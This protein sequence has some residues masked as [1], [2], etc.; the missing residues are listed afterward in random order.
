MSLLPSPRDN[1]EYFEL[2]KSYMGVMYSQRFARLLNTTQNG[3]AHLSLGMR[4]LILI[5]S[6]FTS[7]CFC[8]LQLTLFCFFRPIFKSLYQPRCYCVPNDERMELLPRGLLL[9]VLPTLRHDNA[10]YLSLGLDAY[11]LVR[12]LNVLLLF[13]WFVGSLNV[14]VLAPLNW[15]GYGGQAGLDRL[16]LSNIAPARVYRLNAHCFMALV[17]L[18]LFHWLVIYELQS[19]VKIRQSYLLLKLYKASVMANTVLIKNVPSQWRNL[20]AI[21]RLF[22]GLA[23]GAVQN[24]WFTYDFYGVNDAVSDLRR[25]LDMLELDSVKQLKRQLRLRP[26]VDATFHPPIHL[27]AFVIPVLG[28]R[29]RLSLPGWIR[30]STLAPK[31]HKRQW[32]IKTFAAKLDSVEDAKRLLAEDRIPKHGGVFVQFKTQTMALV[33]HQCLLSQTQGTMDNTLMAFHPRDILWN[34]VLRDNTLGYLL[35]RYIVTVLLIGI[36][37]VYVVP[38][39]LIGFVLHLPSLIHLLPFM[40]WIYRLPENVRDTISSLLPSIL[41]SVLTEIVLIVFRFLIYFKGKPTGGELELDL[42]HWYFAFLLV[43]QFLV[44]TILSSITVV[45]KQ[46]IDQ[47]TSIPILLATNLPKAATFFIQYIAIKAFTFCGNSFLR[48]DQLIM[49]LTVHKFVDKTPRQIFGRLTTLLTLKLGSVYP[50]YSVYASIGIA[51]CIVS[52]MISVFVV[53]ILG[54]SL[55]YYKYAL[56]YIYSHINVSETHGRMYPIALLHMYSGVY[57]LEGC[58]I[59]ILFLL[60]NKTNGSPLKIQGWIMVLVL[61]A[62]IFGHFTI[63]NRF[64]R[65][66][67]LLPIME[68]SKTATAPNND[69]KDANVDEFY[70]N[71]KLLLIHPSFSF[72]APKIWLPQDNLGISAG[73]IAELES[74]IEGLRDGTN[75]GASIEST[76]WK[77]FKIK[78]SEAPPDYK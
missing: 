9:W 53:F 61:L 8:V 55:L 72:E 1:Y 35:E 40:K 67:G 62:T 42:Q 57:C 34:N 3:A 66:F 17:T 49:R 23:P 33:V 37:T 41:L 15:T 52:P 76:F 18:G 26:P 60:R 5:K 25:V 36:T 22:D 65:H 13:F 38:V 28:R 54:L 73:L 71:L 39:S 58:L 43:Q 32:C 46:L 75:R 4:F 69:S 16:N 50:V 2:S 29:I 27:R 77:K 78:V 20:M 51:Y 59:G 6:L 24:V 14:L 68:D 12:F 30:Y 21:R 45:F 44:V 48:I 64:A 31:C 19:F 56:L 11:F 47:P 7:C 10:F 70:L 63:Y 74:S